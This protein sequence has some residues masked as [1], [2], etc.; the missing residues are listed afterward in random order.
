MLDKV[1]VEDTDEIVLEVQLE[2]DVEVEA[3]TRFPL[4]GQIFR[5]A[6]TRPQT[7]IYSTDVNMRLSA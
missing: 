1:E 5:C 7:T 6:T 4:G 2:V 3:K